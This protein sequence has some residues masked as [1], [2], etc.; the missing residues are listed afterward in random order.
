M[1][2]RP[3]GK[4]TPIQL[5]MLGLAGYEVDFGSRKIALPD[6]ESKRM[7][8][9]EAARMRLVGSTGCDFAFDLKKWRDYLCGSEQS[10][11]YCHEYAHQA[12]DSAIRKAIH[13]PVRKRLAKA[14]A[15]TEE[16]GDD[17]A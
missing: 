12:V 14:L 13:D 15:T 5:A 17:A 2:L 9:M 16:S 6:T 8:N 1:T 10:S 3:F 11:G 4:V 7:T